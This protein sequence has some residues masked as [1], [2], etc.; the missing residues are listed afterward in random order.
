MVE[1]HQP[2]QAP[3]LNDS[4]SKLT[5]LFFEIYSPLCAQAVQAAFSGSSR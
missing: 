3:G 2:H 1:K 5:V 4:V